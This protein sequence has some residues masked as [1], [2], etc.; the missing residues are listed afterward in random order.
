VTIVVCGCPQIV[1]IETMCAVY[2]NALQLMHSRIVQ[3]F[4]VFGY[5]SIIYVEMKSKV[6]MIQNFLHV[7]SYMRKSQLGGQYIERRS[8]LMMHVDDNW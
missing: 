3:I 6:V 5:V 1:V 4:L 7:I 8:Q 2:V